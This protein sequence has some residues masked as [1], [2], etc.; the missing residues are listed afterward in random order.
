M[1]DD[2][3]VAM[4]LACERIEARIHQKRR[5]KAIKHFFRGVFLILLFCASSYITIEFFKGLTRLYIG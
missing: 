3:Y 1:S 4:M 2:E 5:N